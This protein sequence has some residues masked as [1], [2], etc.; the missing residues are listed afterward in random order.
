M[1]RL[2]SLLR[3]PSREA[4]GWALVGLGVLLA[5]LGWIGVSG[6][7]IAPLQLPYLASG[8]VAGVLATLVGVGLLISGDLRGDRER[9]GRMES[10]LL[11][12]H[13]TVTQL[14]DELTSRPTGRGRRAG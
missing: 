9:L 1:D 12:L 8:S 10:E 13:D 5:V 6:N 4:A 11:E 2:R 7:D 14:R 3:R